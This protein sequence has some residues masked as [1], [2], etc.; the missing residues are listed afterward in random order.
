MIQLDELMTDAQKAGR[1]ITFKW[2]K[3]H[4][5]HPLNEAADSRANAMA[6]GFQSGQPAPSGPGLTID[7]D[8]VAAT[9]E[10]A[11]AE[12]GITASPNGSV[13]VH[14]PLDRILADEI[15]TRAQQRGIT[16]HQELARVIE[17]GM[18]VL[19]RTEQ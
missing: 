3:G 1:T 19:Y 12:P 10:P 17:A 13:T 18:D 2:V 9:P 14:T 11:E 4:A 15:V 7:N 5:G 6:K 16:P 8:D